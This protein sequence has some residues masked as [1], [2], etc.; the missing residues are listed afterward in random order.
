VS[1]GADYPAEPLIQNTVLNLEHVQ[2]RI[3]LSIAFGDFMDESAF[4]DIQL[5]R[6]CTDTDSCNIPF[7]KAT[8]SKIFYLRIMFSK[9]FQWFIRTFKVQPRLLKHNTHKCFTLANE[10][11]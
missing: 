6:N 4:A 5:T 8:L 1:L 10:M 2:F 7:L 9:S 3:K 11:R